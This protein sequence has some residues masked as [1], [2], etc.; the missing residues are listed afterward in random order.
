MPQ[1]V[2][3]QLYQQAPS[4]H[5]LPN[6]LLVNYKMSTK[7]FPTSYKIVGGDRWELQPFPSIQLQ[8]L[9]VSVALCGMPQQFFFFQLDIPMSSQQGGEGGGGGGGAG[10]HP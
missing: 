6:N 7:Y 4:W 8:S 1:R 5:G 10:G 2:F 3:W 9:V